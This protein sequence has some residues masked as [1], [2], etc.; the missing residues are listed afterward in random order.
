MRLKIVLKQ[1]TSD[2]PMCENPYTVFLSVLVL[3]SCD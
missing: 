3:I 2:A 1:M